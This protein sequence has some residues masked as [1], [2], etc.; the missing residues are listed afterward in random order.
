M[1]GGEPGGASAAFRWQPGPAPRATPR[2][3]TRRRVGAAAG[4]PR[5]GRGRV[6][7]GRIGGHP[8]LL[9]WSKPRGGDKATT[10]PD[11]PRRVKLTQETV[12]SG[13]VAGL[14]TGRTLLVAEP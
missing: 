8:V 3:T 7:R 9:P 4:L 6:S 5:L 13:E 2:R 11:H 14:V 12:R 1:T 10:A